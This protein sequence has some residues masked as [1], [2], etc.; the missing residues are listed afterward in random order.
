MGD[1][2]LNFGMKNICTFVDDGFISVEG[3]DVIFRNF[4]KVADFF[5]VGKTC[6]I[7]FIIQ[8]SV[9]AWGC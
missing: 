4:N 5:F 9:F 2:Q 6:Q 7:Q 3:V 1:R 8:N